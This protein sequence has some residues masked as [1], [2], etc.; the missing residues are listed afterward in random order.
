M[1]IESGS[2]QSCSQIFLVL[3]STRAPKT[4][5]GAPRQTLET[6]ADIIRVRKIRIRLAI[7]PPIKMR[8]WHQFNGRFREEQTNPQ[9]RPLRMS[10]DIE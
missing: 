9:V 1:T 2:I 10:G 7:M 3:K 6:C 4:S 8:G 5:L